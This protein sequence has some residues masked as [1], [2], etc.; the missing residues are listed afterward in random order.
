M[1][2][3]GAEEAIILNIKLLERQTKA[4]DQRVKPKQATTRDF[5]LIY[6]RREQFVS[7][8]GYDELLNIAAHA[9]RLQSNQI[10]L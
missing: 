5:R 3:I 6:N 1:K 2:R 9:C 8:Q 10:R 4:I 7:A